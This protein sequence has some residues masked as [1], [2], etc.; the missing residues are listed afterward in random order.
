MVP[1]S[2]F[3]DNCR[4]RGDTLRLVL[5]L[6][7]LNRL[8]D[9]GD[10]FDVA[11]FR[12]FRLPDNRNAFTFFR[13]AWI[14]VEPNIY[15]LPGSSETNPEFHAFVEANRPAVEMI[16]K[17]AEQVDGISGRV[18]EPLPEENNSDLASAY[19]LQA[20]RAWMIGMM[21]TE[22]TLRDERGPWSGRISR[23][24]PT[25]AR[26]TW[27]MRWRRPSSG[28]LGCLG[29]AT[30][31]VIP[32]AV[33]G[34]SAM[35]KPALLSRIAVYVILR[36]KRTAERADRIASLLGLVALAY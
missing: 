24:C 25:T 34:R 23:A 8:P 29:P 16:I 12:T 13:R 35:S 19:P 30:A 6:T 20:S 4:C 15:Y 21:R 32:S 31:E 5:W 7:S 26:P 22:G 11:A 33:R 14:A 3:S 10:P 27:P 28:G 1:F 9:I 2:R 36:T 17:G 18:C